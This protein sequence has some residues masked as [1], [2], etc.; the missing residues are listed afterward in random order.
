MNLSELYE[1]IIHLMCN[2]L[3]YREILYLSALNR[4]FNSLITNSD[5]WSSMLSRKIP[6]YFDEVIYKSNKYSKIKLLAWE[7]RD[8]KCLFLGKSI[9]CPGRFLHRSTSSIIND[10]QSLIMGGENDVGDCLNDVWIISYNEKEFSLTFSKV[11]IIENSTLPFPRKASAICTVKKESC[12]YMFGGASNVWV[13]EEHG[14]SNGL[15]KLKLYE[16][17]INNN[18]EYSAQWYLVCGESV[19]NNLNEHHPSARWGHVL[20]LIFSLLSFIFLLFFF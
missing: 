13:E 14:F 20:V 5:I 1:C 8:F 17:F 9:N 3:D 11:R 10:R 2:Y 12:I 15:W 16:N 4:N 19:T 7:R 18:V 6:Y